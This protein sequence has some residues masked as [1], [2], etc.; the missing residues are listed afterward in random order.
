MTFERI[1]SFNDVE[2]DE[3]LRVE[4]DG[5]PTL[6][7]WRVD[8][9]P[10]VTDDTCTHGAASLVKEGLQDGFVIEC[11]L[12]LGGFDVR[13]GSITSPP[14]TE[15]LRCYP[16]ELR[17]D[18]VF[19]DLDGEAA[20]TGSDEATSTAATVSATPVALDQ[21]N[22]G[23]QQAADRLWAA[24]Q[25]G[26]PCSPVRDLLA[27][28]DVAAAY[29]AQQINIDRRIADGRARV[30]GRKIGLTSAAVQA[31]VGVDTP[32]YGVLLSD[33]VVDDGGIL[34]AG[35]LLQPRAEAEICLVLG[36]DLDMP[37]PTQAD[38]L[39]ATEYVL[40]SIEIVDSRVENWD[41][42]IVDTIADNASCGAFVL[43]TPARRPAD[44]DFAH[45]EMTMQ[46]NGETRSTGS[47]RACLGNPL[48]AAVWLAR[49]M[50]DLGTPLRAGEIV[51]T[52]ALGPLVPVVEG[53]QVEATISDLGSVLFTH[54]AS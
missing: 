11:G 4:I 23:D 31:Q 52:G 17:D 13:D 14:C 7:V 27:S 12:H 25:A 32:D 8:D 28:G 3:G 33:M 45:C 39:R 21:S 15:A 44:I 42:S 5:R 34:E 41:I 19:A 35:R 10:Y 1:C 22:G 37:F 50:Y 48:N 36:T 47:G 24:A 49:V 43:G 54:A 51:L 18:E 2:D 26:T 16:A 9:R 6:A 46:I 38:V 20:G 53:D 30:V 40:P 29:R